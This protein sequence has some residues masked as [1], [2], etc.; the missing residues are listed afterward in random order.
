MNQPD[1]SRF[2]DIYH[3]LSAQADTVPLSPALEAPGT[4]PVS[5]EVLRDKI[6]EMVRGLQAC[7]VTRTSR[8]AIVRQPVEPSE[9]DALPDREQAVA[10]N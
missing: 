7:G 10:G 2:T 6:R 5:Y 4:E 8:V 1:S 9:W 3:L